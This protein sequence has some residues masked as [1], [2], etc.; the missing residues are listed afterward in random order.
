MLGLLN[1]KKSV[2]LKRRVPRCIERVREKGH[3]PNV[4][5]EPPIHWSPCWSSGYHQSPYTSCRG[6]NG[7][8]QLYIYFKDHNSYCLAFAYHTSYAGEG[9]VIWATN[10]CG[11]RMIGWQNT[12]MYLQCIITLVA[13][14]ML[15]TISVC[16][17]FLLWKHICDWYF[18]GA[19]KP[20]HNIRPHYK[21]S[22]YFFSSSSS[23][24]VSPSSSLQVGQDPLLSLIHPLVSKTFLSMFVWF[25]SHSW[26]PLVRT[27]FNVTFLE[28]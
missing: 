13:R 23:S 2:G 27:F 6:S 12:Y 25:M 16:W 22:Y 10:C 14:V 20:F 1:I 11:F 8:E 21:S 5:L 19:Q 7:S 3:C 24:V 18:E 15:V 9:K 28:T 26:P 17:Q 4:V